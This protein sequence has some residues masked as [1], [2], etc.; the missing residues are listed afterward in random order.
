MNLSTNHGIEA[1]EGEGGA[2]P[3]PLAHRAIPLSGSP[4][5]IEWAERIRLQVTAEFDRVAASFRMVADRQSG[6]VRTDTETILAILEDKRIEVLGIASAGYFIREWQEISDQVRQM[7]FHDP[8]YRAI[9]TNR[10]RR[11]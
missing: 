5:Q 2:T 11:R 1:W 4:G 7:I 9:K 3:A 8:R 10:T 6:E